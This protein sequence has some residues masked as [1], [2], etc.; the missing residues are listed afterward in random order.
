MYATGV[1]GVLLVAQFMW[2]NKKAPEV[3][4]SIE[5]GGSGGYT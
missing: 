5:A 2:W 3:L 4:K 1:M